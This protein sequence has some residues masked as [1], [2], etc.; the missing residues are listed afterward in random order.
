MGRQ[1]EKKIT[2]MKKCLLLLGVLSLAFTAGS[3]LRCY[4]CLV[5]GCSDPY[6]S[7]STHIIT[8]PA[9]YPYCAKLD[10]DN[11]DQ[12]G[13]LCIA[14]PGLVSPTAENKQLSKIQELL[15]ARKYNNIVA[16]V[17]D[18]DLCNGSVR[19]AEISSM[20]ILLPASL[21]LLISFFS[22]L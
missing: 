7:N 2:T 16:H 17:C 14:F 11:G 10:F 6:S 4:G 9:G 12:F 1:A 5:D 15:A 13:R 3:A 19:L 18:R 8:C 22:R 20:M 21:V